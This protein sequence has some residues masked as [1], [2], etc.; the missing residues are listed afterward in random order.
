V[1]T[2]TSSVRGERGAVIITLGGVEIVDSARGW[3]FD[4]DFFAFLLPS[5]FAFEA[6]FV[7]ETGALNCAVCITLE[8]LKKETY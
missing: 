5:F 2:S 6:S 1:S 3:I 8:L 7:L 4:E